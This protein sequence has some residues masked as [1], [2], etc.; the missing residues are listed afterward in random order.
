MRL[1]CII[2]NLEWAPPHGRRARLI[3]EKISSAAPDVVCCTETFSDFFSDGYSIESSAEF[4]YV[5]TGSRRK[6][7]LWS[8]QAWQDVDIIGDKGMPPG[9]FVSGITGGVRF[10]GVCIP[11]K[12]A[13]VR[14][15]NR[16]RLPWQDHLAY[17]AGLKRVLEKY[18]HSSPVCLLGD[19]NQRLPRKNQP[20][21]VNEALMKA[22]PGDFDIATEGLMDHE[23][24]MLIDHL[25][26]SAGLK[27]RIDNLFP[28]TAIDGTRLTDH[29]GIVASIKGG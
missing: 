9:R 21:H 19:F 6:V 22:I 3:R 23:N 15:G 17:C 18:R 10:V 16:N 28:R 13:H 7:L 5:H 8:R 29:T 20:V 27:A 2:W 14:T 12:D 25:A 11:W 26:V 4:G 1:G 24:K